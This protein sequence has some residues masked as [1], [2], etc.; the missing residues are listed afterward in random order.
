MLKRLICG[1]VPLAL[2]GTIASAVLLQ[3][4]ASASL[5]IP[6]VV[7]NNSVYPVTYVEGW[8]NR[9]TATWEHEDPYECSTGWAMWYITEGQASPS[10][11]DPDAVRF[12]SNCVTSGYVEKTVIGTNIKERTD[13]SYD[14]SNRV[15]LWV[16]YQNAI[17][18][19]TD[20]YIQHKV[21]AGPTGLHGTGS[22]SSSISLAWNPIPEAIYSIY[23][24]SLSNLR[25]SQAGTSFTDSGLQPNTTY[26][27]YV[28]IRHTA[29][30][31]PLVYVTLATS[32]PPPPPPTQISPDYYP[33]YSG[34]QYWPVTT[35]ANATGYNPNGT[36]A[37]TLWAGTSYVLCKTQAGTYYG[38]YGQNNLWLWTE[39][40]SPAGS[41]GWVSA[42]FLSN[43]GDNQAYTDYGAEIEWCSVL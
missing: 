42:Y 24:D 22:T 28:V 27:Y 23:R 35:F 29:F 30:D 40:D 9:D 18:K 39:L 7:H 10:S 4:P 37:G 25:S 36:S 26:T 32:T 5:G 21:C 8:C 14:R 1:A 43:W 19:Y 15:S 11:Q 17:G 38:T 13:F 2:I 41:Y 6:P 33:G 31:S 16:G 3:S 20:I 34:T 12:D